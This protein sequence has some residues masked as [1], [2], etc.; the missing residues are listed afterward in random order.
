MMTVRQITV[1]HHIEISDE[2]FDDIQQQN[3]LST[4]LQIFG[5]VI[6]GGITVGGVIGLIAPSVLKNMSEHAETSSYIAGAVALFCGL[7]C[8][9]SCGRANMEVE[10]SPTFT[11]YVEHQ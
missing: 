8:L 5:R 7:C 6:G 11:G 9:C 1:M 4:N 10:I 2:L 3:N